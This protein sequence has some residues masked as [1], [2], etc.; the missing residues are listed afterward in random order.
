MLGFHIKSCF[1][2]NSL[3]VCVCVCV[4]VF[5]NDWTSSVEVINAECLPQKQG[6]VSRRTCAVC[7]N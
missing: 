3:C 7:Q 4:C 6:A 1:L 5:R 2:N